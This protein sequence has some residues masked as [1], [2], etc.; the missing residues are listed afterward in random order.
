[1]NEE[2][3]Y[4]LHIYELDGIA[5]VTRADVLSTRLCSSQPGM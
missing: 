3:R 4:V 1:M 2:F 5:T